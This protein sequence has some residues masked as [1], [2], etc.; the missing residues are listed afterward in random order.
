MLCSTLAPLAGRGR[1]DTIDVYY[2]Q[3]GQPLVARWPGTLNW[4]GG[5]ELRAAI[6]PAFPQLELPLGAACLTGVLGTF[7]LQGVDG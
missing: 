4:H 5:T 1:C 6:H 3:A 2:V 7:G